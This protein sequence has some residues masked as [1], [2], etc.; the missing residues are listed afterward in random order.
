MQ[1]ERLVIAFAC[2][3]VFHCAQITNAQMAGSWEV[4][5]F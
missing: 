4:S 1:H 3:I 5:L 2:L